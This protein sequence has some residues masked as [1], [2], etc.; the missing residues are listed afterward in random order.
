LTGDCVC[1]SIA[2]ATGKP[3]QEIYN[4]LAKGNATQ[5]KTKRESK[6]KQ[7]VRTA[8]RGINVKRKWFQDYMQSLGFTWVSC[9]QIGSGCKVHLRD[10]ELPMGK[11]VVTVSK[12]STA[13]I[14]GCINDTH[15][16]SRDGTRCVY[17]YYILN[18][19]CL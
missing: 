16:C 19:A 9:M 15:D 13:V 6:S 4:A 10:G 2:I 18:K 12:H 1:R 17:G 8:A 14:D 7:G 11:L 3:Y 5:R